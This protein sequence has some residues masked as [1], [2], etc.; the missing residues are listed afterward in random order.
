MPTRKN[1]DEYLGDRIDPKELKNWSDDDPRWDEIVVPIADVWNW[2]AAMLLVSRGRVVMPPDGE[3][4]VRW[5]KQWVTPIEFD[6]ALEEVKRMTPDERGIF[7]RPLVG[8]FD[9]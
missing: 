6:A 9:A 7:I 5:V 4:Q 2:A 1:L 8:D 3:S